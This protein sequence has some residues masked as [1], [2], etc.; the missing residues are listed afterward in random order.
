MPWQESSCPSTHPCSRQPRKCKCW[1]AGRQTSKKV[2]TGMGWGVLLCKSFIVNSERL[3]PGIHKTGQNSIGSS[4][5]SISPIIK[6]IF[7]ISSNSDWMLMAF[8]SS[9]LRI[10]I[11]EAFLGALLVHSHEDL[12]SSHNSAD[13][14]TISTQHDFQSVWREM[15]SFRS[16]RSWHLPKFALLALLAVL[17][18]W[19]PREPLR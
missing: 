10:H 17:P 18:L 15:C 9:L 12:S 1:S 16:W 2:Q 19:K 3:Q 4:A 14:P 11:K 13:F 7:W 5:E 6:S 8:L